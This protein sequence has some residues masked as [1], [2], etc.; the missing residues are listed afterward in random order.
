MSATQP[1]TTTPDDLDRPLVLRDLY[2]LTQE[3]ESLRADVARTLDIAQNMG[4]GVLAFGEQ[5]DQ[6]LQGAQGGMLGKL[7]GIPKGGLP[8]APQE[9]QDSAQAPWDPECIGCPPEGS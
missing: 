7:L 8:K 1:T 2:A 4:A 3:V 5:F 9:P 6:L